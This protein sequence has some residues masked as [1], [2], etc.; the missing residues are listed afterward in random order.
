MAKDINEL[1]SLVKADDKAA[2]SE[3]EEMFRP[4]IVAETMKLISSNPFLRSDEDEIRQEALIGLYKAAE[5]YRADSSSE[6]TEQ[7]EE[8]GSKGDAEKS[9]ENAKVTF[10]LYAKICIHNRMIS[11]LRK[12]RSRKARQEKALAA[13]RSSRIG[14]Y[15]DEFLGAME[16]NSDIRRLF[17]ENTTSLE[18]RIFL[19]YLD[20][21]SYK[22]I[23]GEVGKTEKS[24][25]NAIYRVKTKMKKLLT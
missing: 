20:N 6:E 8:T 25:D 3:L 19:M 13:Q 21:K 14:S 7:G 5:S 10:G 18:K 24:V 9:K 22:E 11:Y 4:L 17:E 23:A 16:H 15:T 1:L 12:A 2:F